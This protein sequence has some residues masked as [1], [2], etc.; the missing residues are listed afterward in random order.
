MICIFELNYRSARRRILGVGAYLFLWLWSMT[1]SA[2]T[3]STAEVVA[4]FKTYK[5]AVVKQD[6]KA[7]VPVISQGTIDYFGAILKHDLESP[8]ADVEKLR[9]A[10]KLLVLRARHQ[11]PSE[12]LRKMSAADFFAYGID[13][14]WTTKESIVG[15]DLGRVDIS[16][17]TAKAELIVGGKKAPA[18]MV[19]VF[20][21]EKGAWKLDM[22]PMMT[23][24][25]AMFKQAIRAQEIEENEFLFNILESVSGRKVSEDVWKPINAK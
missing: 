11:V 6:G 22:I 18:S 10:D 17:D 23:R 12:N 2:Q 21:K 3:D 8:K 4:S 7:A 24:V 9:T 20:H 19:Y 14:G 1:G 13:K 25:D 16:G 15:L 5:E